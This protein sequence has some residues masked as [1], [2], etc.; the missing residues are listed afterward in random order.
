MAEAGELQE[1]AGGPQVHPAR[2]GADTCRGRPAGP[3]VRAASLRT[4]HGTALE[5]R[6]APGSGW[7]REQGLVQ[8]AARGGALGLF[9]E[10]Q[11][12]RARMGKESGSESGYGRQVCEA[13]GVGS[14]SSRKGQEGPGVVLG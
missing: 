11:S 7:S 6:G 3:W 5:G 2:T 4:A 9:G 8:G 13:P 10:L 1:Q 14:W 12:S